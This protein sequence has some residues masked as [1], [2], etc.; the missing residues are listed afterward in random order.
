MDVG[1]I[2]YPQLKGTWRLSVWMQPRGHSQVLWLCFSKTWDRGKRIK[3]FGMINL[4]Y[5]I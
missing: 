3:K 5:I 2:I 4:I 1:P